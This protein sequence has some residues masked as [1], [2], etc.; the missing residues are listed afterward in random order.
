M[1]I[2][3]KYTNETDVWY[4]LNNK[5]RCSKPTKFSIE[6]GY[7]GGTNKGWGS[8]SFPLIIKYVVDSKFD[9]NNIWINEK[10]LF[11]SK[12]ELLKSL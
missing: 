4:I 10:E 11:I 8:D 1:K 9:G 7:S 3:I 5:I 12:E 2:E 6:C